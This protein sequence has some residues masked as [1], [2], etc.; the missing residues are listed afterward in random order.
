MA[1]FAEVLTQIF[2][3]REAEIPFEVPGVWETLQADFTDPSWGAIWSH[4]IDEDFAD[5]VLCVEFDDEYGLNIVISRPKFNWR[6]HQL[7]VLRGREL[8]RILV[9]SPPSDDTFREICTSV[10]DGITQTRRSWKTCKHCGCRQPSAYMQEPGV[11]MG[12]A[13]TVLGIIY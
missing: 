2:D 1:T 11:C 5:C 4:S 3:P 7:Q 12:C 10:A 9:A 13:P 8:K 6:V